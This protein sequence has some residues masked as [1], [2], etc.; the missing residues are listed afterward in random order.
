[1]IV[2][3]TSTLI[4]IENRAYEVWL[5]HG[6]VFC[7]LLEVLLAQ[8]VSCSTWHSNSRI[9]TES[10]RTSFLFYLGP[11]DD[12]AHTRKPTKIPDGMR[13]L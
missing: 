10:N 4:F 6:G 11:M 3:I 12:D 1:M 9:E 7:F 5:H 2:A 8:F 13:F